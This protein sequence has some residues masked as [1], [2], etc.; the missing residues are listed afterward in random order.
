MS[1]L[2]PALNLPDPV[3]PTPAPARLKSLDVFRGITI[4]A[5]LLVNNPGSWSH[6][7]YPLGHA[8]W[9][10]C[11][12]TDLIFPFFLF[13]VG[14]ACT[15]SLAKRSATAVSKLAVWKKVAF[16]SVILFLLGLFLAAIPSKFGSTES[17]TSQPG[18]QPATQ[19]APKIERNG[20]LTP[21]TL[22][23]PGVLQRIGVCYLVAATILLFIPWPGQL[24]ISIGLLI[25]NGWL[26][27]HV[28]YGPDGA[29]GGWT[30]DNNL[31]GYVDARVMG[32][33]NY[34]FQPR[35]PYTFDP[36]GI[37]ST[38]PA[39]VTT[40]LGALAGRVLRGS[41]EPAIKI[42]GLFTL[43]ILTTAVAWG[44]IIW[45]MPLNK[46]LWTPSYAVF[47]AGL[48][49]LGLGVCCWIIDIKGYVKWAAPFVWFGMN[50]IT[51]FVLAGV[52]GRLLSIIRVTEDNIQLGVFLKGKLS[53]GLI[54]L[55]GD[56]SW[57]V[58]PYN[59]SLA[60]AI[61][62]ILVF[63]VLMWVLY[64]LKIFIKV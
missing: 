42:G 5:M 10:G 55:F 54:N 38:L 28:P 39:I 21:G 64:A 59:L 45:W 56:G 19:V 3:P 25:L 29:K 52:V 32:S 12:P 51:A 62:F 57:F 24:L 16:R 49:M 31:A 61:A 2:Q 40:L 14:V 50:A 11:T 13:I 35:D 63:T 20:I 46:Q 33:H 23:I 8:E 15:F 34:K 36:E 44:M 1:I 43:G 37:V 9:D 41:S 4:A 47:T 53:T 30:P 17:A 26:M 22:R 48:A 18:T 6:V 58:N 60:W 27:L 7:Y